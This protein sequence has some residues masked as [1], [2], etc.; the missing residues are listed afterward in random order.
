MKLSR[1]YD[2]GVAPTPTTTTATPATN[3]KDIKPYEI[4]PKSLAS[5]TTEFMKKMID[6]DV[7]YSNRVEMR[8]EKLILYKSR[9]RGLRAVPKAD[10]TFSH[11]SLTSEELKPRKPRFE[12]KVR[13]GYD[14]N[15]YN[16]THYDVNNPP[17]KM[18]QGYKFNIFYA[19]LIDKTVTPSWAL[20][21][22]GDST[23]DN[24]TVQLRFTAGPPYQD[25]AFRILNRE[26]DTHPNAHFVNKFE[27]GILQLHFSLKRL[28]YRK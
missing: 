28:R 19:D 15:R 1:V 11:T 27:K 23:D 14:W 22:C 13:T 17:P 10:G 9:K 20:E 24:N 4:T 5:L 8:K 3:G 18:V 25:I 2:D 12:N 21:P 6:A 26:W 7:D 16:Q